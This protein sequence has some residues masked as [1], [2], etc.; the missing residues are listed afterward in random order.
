MRLHVSHIGSR[1]ASLVDRSYCGETHRSGLLR[2][3]SADKGVGPAANIADDRPG[4]CNGNS[5]GVKYPLELAQKLAAGPNLR[6][7]SA[8]AISTSTSSVQRLEGEWFL[9][10]VRT[11]V[12]DMSAGGW[13]SE[14]SIKRCS[15]DVLRC[16]CSQ[17][18]GA[19]S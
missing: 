8:A 10:G 18:A 12:A 3:V 6:P 11:Q 5:P 17:A 1:Q 2:S 9:L 4:S 7:L 16:S 14:A 15:A 19:K 13:A